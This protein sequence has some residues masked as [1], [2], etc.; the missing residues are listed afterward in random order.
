MHPVLDQV[1]TSSVIALCL[2]V[3]VVPSQ[4]DPDAWIEHVS[5]ETGGGV[6]ESVELRGGGWWSRG[7][8]PPC[9]ARVALC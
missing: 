8:P 3:M 2:G 5:W 6:V 7:E 9:C 4:F 1:V